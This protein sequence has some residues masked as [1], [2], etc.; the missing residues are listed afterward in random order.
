MDIDMAKVIVQI[1][2][3]LNTAQPEYSGCYVV[4]R[5]ICLIMINGGILSCVGTTFENA[6]QRCSVS[7]FLIDSVSSSWC[8]S[9]TRCVAEPVFTCRD[10]VRCS[11]LLRCCEIV[12]ALLRSIDD[13]GNALMMRIVLYCSYLLQVVSP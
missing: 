1:D 11:N 12:E 7:K 3:W 2:T 5:Y 6:T 10:E 8:F 9:C 13:D 4:V